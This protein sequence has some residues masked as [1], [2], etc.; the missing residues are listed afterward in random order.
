MISQPSSSDFEELIHVWEASVRS[1]HHFLTEEDIQYFKPLVRNQY[2]PAVALFVVRNEKKR[3]AA[4]IGL[5]D[6]CIEMLFVHPDDQG[7]GYGKCLID[8]A[9]NEKLICKVDVNEQNENA[10][11]FYRR[12][13]FDVTG[14][15]AT[16]SSGKPFP[17]LHMAMVPAFANLLLS[18]RFH[19]E[20]IRS[21]L[22][23]IKYNEQRRD[24]LYKLTS[25]KDDSTSY[26]AL[27]VCTHLPAS[28]REWLQTK[29]EELIN[30]V[31]TCPHTGKRRIFLQLLER[32]TFADSPRV[33]FLDFCLE[34]MFSNQEPVGV[35]SLCIKLAYKLCQS[36]PELMQEFRMILD[37]QKGELLSPAL[38][39]SRR[40]I[41]KAMNKKKT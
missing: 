28:G 36:I 13:G 4:F 10:F 29:Q 23:V 30:A 14:R 25:D 20:D 15:D 40:S 6:E 31:M 37:M 39:S 26:L 16:D 24:E 9:V 1:T 17:I 22:Y 19:M 41:L 2:F 8:F 12:R 21:L 18:K 7:K 3:I 5:S 11:L 38:R 33:D 34:R 27:W 32:Q 35:Q